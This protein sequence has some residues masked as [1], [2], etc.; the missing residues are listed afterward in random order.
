MAHTSPIVQDG[1]LTYSQ[2]GQTANCAVD[3]PDWYNWLEIASTFTFRSASGVFTARKEQAGNKRGG[4]YWRAYRKR[5]GKL[6]R[7]YLGKSEDITL[8]RLNAIAVV[9]AGTN[10]K[11]E[12]FDTQE[13]AR[14]ADRASPRLSFDLPLPLT[15]L[16]GREQERAALGAMLKRPEVRL[17]T[18]TG[19]G[20]VGKTRL[21]LE[22]AQFS[23]ADFADGVCFVALAGTLDLT[24]VIPLVAQALGLWEAI[25]HPPL[26][27]VQDYLREKHLLLLLDNFEQVLAAAPLLARLLAFCPRLC[28]LVTSRAVLHISGEHE[29]AVSP[30]VVPALTQL[31]ALTDL[32]QVATV[33]LFVERAQA[34]KTDVQLT[35]GNAR[36]IAEICVRLDGLTLAVELAA[37]RIK[38]LPPQALLKRLS[39]RLDLLTGGAQDLPAR[40]QTLRNTLQWSYDLLSAEEQRLFRWLSIFVG[41]FTLE[42]ATAVC[43][44][45]SDQPLDVLTGVAS[46]LDKSLL[47]QTEQEGEEPRFRMLETLREF[48]LACLSTNGEGAAAE[49]AHAWYY[50]ALAE[51]P[52]RIWRV[53][54]W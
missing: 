36:T 34:V 48:G 35:Q 23:R 8:E 50:L 17:L 47:L 46:L 43:N 30:L 18:L 32:A 51:E 7:A 20:G 54:S 49:W 39:Q 3:T 45:G 16:I 11:D 12:T 22:V 9:V 14:P 13:G 19:P 37:A 26:E 33:R 53:P 4:Q 21:A 52:S 6:H 28:I 27:Q 10:A 38:L 5:N 2:N 15:A 29:F 31:P 25:D 24:R 44:A 42:A 40:Q 1:M 41:G